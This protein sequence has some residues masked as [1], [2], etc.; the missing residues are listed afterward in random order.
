MT[1]E[2]YRR[3]EW[4][5]TLGKPLYSLR[6]AKAGTGLAFSIRCAPPDLQ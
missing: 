6:R 3:E 1:L 4:N 5:E 2:V